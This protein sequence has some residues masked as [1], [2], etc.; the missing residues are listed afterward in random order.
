[1]TRRVWVWI[2]LV[3]A[4]VASGAPAAAQDSQAFD[5]VY[6]G[7][8]GCTLRT[9]SG[10]PEGSLT[11][12]VCD[13]YVNSATGDVYTKQSGTGNTGWTI[14]PRLAAA[15][16]WTGV[17]TFSAQILAA[18]GTVSAPAYAFGSAPGTGMYLSGSSLRFSRAGVL[19]ALFESSSTPRLQL[20]FGLDLGGNGDANLYK[21]A[22]NVIAQRN[23]TSNQAF[24]VY[25]TYTDGSNWERG[26]LTT[27]AT[28]FRVGTHAAGTGTVRNLVFATGGSGRWVVNAASTG[29]VPYNDNTS[30]IGTASA[31]VRA[32]FLGANGNTSLTTSGAWVLSG[33]PGGVSASTRYISGG[34]A[35]NAWYVNVPTGGT[36][37]FAVNET[38]VARVT[39]T[40]LT[41]AGTG[42]FNSTTATAGDATFAANV[43]T[44]SFVSQTTG[45][46]ATAAGA[47][48]VR[49]LYTD[50]MRAKL[51]TADLESVLAG[52]SR[53]TKSFSVVSQTFTCPALS[54]TSTLWVKD[55]PTYGDAAVFVSGDSVVIRSQTRSA[56]GPFTISDCVGVVTSYADG[57]GANAGQQSWTFTRNAGG[58]GGAMSASTTVA[59]N[60]LVQDLGTTGNGY[61]ETTAVDGAAGVN[62]PYTQI[63]TWA[64]APV[65]ANLTT[66]CRLGN[67]RGLT[68][69][70]EYGLFCGN[71]SGNAFVRFSDQN[72]E[73]RGIPL[74]LYDGGT[75][76]VRLDASVPSF[77]M[78]ST[79]PSAFGTGTGIW[80]GKDTTYKFRVGDPAGN[81][82]SYDGN[83]TL[84]SANLTI[85]SSG[86]TVA[87]N[88]VPDTFTTVRAFN[89]TGGG[90]WGTGGWSNGQDRGVI[91]ANERNTATAGDT[92]YVRL[93]S[94]ASNAS[95]AEDTYLTLKSHTTSTSGEAKLK[96]YTV[97]IGNDFTSAGPGNGV[98]RLVNGVLKFGHP[99]SA[100]W[101]LTFDP[102]TFSSGYLF[103]IGNGSALTTT[104]VSGAVR[105][106]DWVSGLASGLG[107]ETGIS[108]GQGYVMAYNR[109]SS[110]YATLNLV[111][112]STTIALDGSTVAIAGPVTTTSTIKE[113]SRSTPMGEWISVAYS[114][115]S[116]TAGSSMTW[117]V[118]SGDVQVYAYTLVGK[119]MTVAFGVNTT[120]VGGTAAADLRIAIPGGFTAAK[121]VDSTFNYYDGA[122][123]STGLARVSTGS[124]LI[125]LF[126]S[127]AAPAWVLGTNTTYVT[128]TITFEIS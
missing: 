6:L 42:T 91:I 115:G 40:G 23:S 95:T 45:W 77:A 8:A 32:L 119:M 126:R 3:L 83:L 105:A 49:Y 16:S 63:V 22:A 13:T 44:S 79:L 64:T 26:E 69:V 128:G 66:R 54:G 94:S 71:F 47:L 27:S 34:G 109:T 101:L 55:A 89:F 97:D 117:T 86:V 14:V 100:S 38:E 48:D 98:L 74:K 21:D 15:N 28:E 30:D 46:R 68:S 5:K 52:S 65:S 122:T 19:A 116:Y 72:A 108:G 120:T 7:S 35:S 41:L 103:S 10:S 106:K 56:F 70:T 1:M 123:A 59:V 84:V 9:G 104:E 102:N 53:V 58:N 81:R 51:F 2:V 113:R 33:S 12:S 39:G 60:E 107:L 37:Y 114:A 31:R 73:I 80:M 20:L 18:D 43:G 29:F 88:T 85:D 67:L 124:G 82:L 111:S 62:A 93:V 96:A 25:N 36:T 78:G 76:T 24:R 118:D 121:V 11:G 112:G 125:F 90:N 61:V 4:V 110:A 99:T 87:P 57:S 92:A 75:E 127:I 50:E 17:Q